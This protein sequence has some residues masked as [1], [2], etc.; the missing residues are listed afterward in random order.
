MNCAKRD[1][2]Q[3]N[4][5]ADLRVL[6]DTTNRLEGQVFGFDKAFL[7]VGMA[8]LEG[9][10]APEGEWTR[11][12]GMRPAYGPAAQAC[13]AFEDSRRKVREH[14]IEHGCVSGAGAMDAD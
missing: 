13:Y 7:R 11:V 6:I 10:A 12:A 3:S 4:L 9:G 2:L 5:G 14:V 8:G 1:S